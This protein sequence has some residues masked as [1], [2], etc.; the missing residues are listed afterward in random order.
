M[1]I[2]TIIKMALEVDYI[3][4]VNAV[5]KYM[6]GNSVGLRENFSVMKILYCSS[7]WFCFL[8]RIDQ[9]FPNLTQTF[10]SIFQTTN[11]RV[12]ED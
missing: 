5:S 3:E 10:Y 11:E 9:W 8:F 1:E 2:H 12:K 4:E 6:S 7:K